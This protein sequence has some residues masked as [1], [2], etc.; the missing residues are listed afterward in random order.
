MGWSKQQQQKTEAGE[1]EAGGDE[2]AGQASQIVD[3]RGGQLLRD[4]N[5]PVN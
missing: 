4:L 3:L 5:L 2:K 1:E